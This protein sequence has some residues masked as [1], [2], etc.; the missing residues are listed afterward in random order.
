MAE[1]ATVLVVDDD[2]PFLEVAERSLR[3]HDY[4]VL[5]ARS[6]PDA[7]SLLMSH[8]VD[9][10]LLDVCMPDMNGFALLEIMRFIPRLVQVPVIL[11]SGDLSPA[12]RE[13]AQHLGVAEILN[14]PFSP[15]EMVSAVASAMAQTAVF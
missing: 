10:V 1:S 9:L 15:S 2:G 3:Q 12:E 8:R 11:C 14:K 4:R 6:G 7:I 13:R 5:T